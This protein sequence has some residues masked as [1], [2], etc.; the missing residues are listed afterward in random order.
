MHI[1]LTGRT[2][3]GKSTLIKKYTEAKGLTPC[4]FATVWGAPA[5]DGGRRLYMH[6]YGKI[7]ENTEENLLARFLPDSPS[8]T[9]FPKVFD[10]LGADYLTCR[11]GADLLVMDELGFLESDSHVFQAAVL[12]ALDGPLPVLGVIKPRSTPFLDAV[13]SHPKVKVLE[14]TPETRDE[15]LQQ[16]LSLSFEETFS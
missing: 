16:L 7:G 15:L 3:I 9:R 11:E 6:P 12:S 4:G 1:F 14:V 2:R 10:T 13:R 5:E 8:A